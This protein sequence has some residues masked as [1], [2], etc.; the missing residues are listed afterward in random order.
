MRPSEKGDYI[1]F[2]DTA[3]EEIRRIILIE[4]VDMDDSSNKNA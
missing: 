2:T 3:A 4:I 1:H